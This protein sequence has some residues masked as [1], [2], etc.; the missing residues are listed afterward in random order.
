MATELLLTIAT[1]PL[2]TAGVRDEARTALAIRTTGARYLTAALDKHY[3]F[4]HDV[5]SF[6]LRSV[7]SIARALAG[8]RGAGRRAGR[9]PHTCSIPRTARRTSATSPSPS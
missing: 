7:R 6:R 4:L 2:T 8:M 1:D 9:S 5:P 3:D